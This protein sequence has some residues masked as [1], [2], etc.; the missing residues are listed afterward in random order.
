MIQKVGRNSV[1]LQNHW[2]S[3]ICG[4]LGRTY[5][6]WKKKFNNV[7]HKCFCKRRV[8]NTGVI[9][10]KE[11]R[12]LTEERKKLKN[13][14][15]VSF[16]NSNGLKQIIRKLD[17]VIDQKISD[18]NIAIIKKNI[19]K[20]GEIDK[21]SFWKMKKLLAPKSKEMPHAVIDNHDNLL[22]DLV[23]IRNEYIT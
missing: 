5:Q 19:G 6:T 1:H 7:L 10:N 2:I 16:S 21:Q 22:T 4:Q 14:L 13:K 20:T 17:T 18:F 12:T 8:G 3:Q 23:T 11:I 9:Y 15:A